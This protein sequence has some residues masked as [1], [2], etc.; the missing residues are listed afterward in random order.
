[1]IG[2]IRMLTFVL[3][4]LNIII[5]PICWR[6]AIRALAKADRPYT[7]IT[8]AKMPDKNSKPP[9]TKS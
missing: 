1:M 2:D 5:L 8:R 9:K 7:T 6:K 4:I 3:I